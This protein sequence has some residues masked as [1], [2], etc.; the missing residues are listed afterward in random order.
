[1]PSSSSNRGVVRFW[2]CMTVITIP[3]WCSLP[4]RS[5]SKIFPSF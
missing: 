4:R 2:L 1:L 5:R 3:G